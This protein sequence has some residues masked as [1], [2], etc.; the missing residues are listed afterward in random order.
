VVNSISGFLSSQINNVL[1]NILTNKLNISGLYVNFSGSLYNPNPFGEGGSGFSYD[2]TNFNL[3]IGKTF[4]NNRVVLTFEGSYDVPFQSS[5]TQLKSDLLNNFT[6]EFLLNKS[7]SIR[8][9]IFYKENVDFLSG[10]STSGNNKS[11]RY[12]T[13]LAYR[14]EFNKLS[15][16]FGK[17][18]RLKKLAEAKEKKENE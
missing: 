18:K 11:R 16:L 17:K 8:A 9:T 13:S 12:G 14:K 7:G 5:A 2:R 3:A 15:E 10:T 1:N 6:T 4:F